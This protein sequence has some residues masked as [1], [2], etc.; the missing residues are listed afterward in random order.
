[1]NNSNTA[2]TSNSK[3]P[4][5]VLPNVPMDEADLPSTKSATEEAI[6]RLKYETAGYP[7]DVNGDGEGIN[8]EG[9]AKSPDETNFKA[10]LEFDGYQAIEEYDNDAY[11]ANVDQ[12][13]DPAQPLNF[14]DRVELS[15]GEESPIDVQENRK[16]P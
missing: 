2:Q 9:E 16:T 13:P 8:E 4:K 7:L 14:S 10:E 5:N 12:K 15:T 3:K 1:M 6:D 11:G